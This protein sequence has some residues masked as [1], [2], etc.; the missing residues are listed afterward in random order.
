[1]RHFRT[2]EASLRLPGIAAHWEHYLLCI[3]LH[4]ILPLLPLGIEWWYTGSVSERSLTLGAALYSICIGASSR[5]AIFFVLTFVAGLVFA[6]AFGMA[7][8]SG[9]GL[10][11]IRWAALYCVSGV[12]LL[13]AL[14]RFIRHV[15]D[16][17]PFLEFVA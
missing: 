16:R 6:I 1:M 8:A 2:R 17:T 7:A 3:L 12:F 11:G 9:P 5:R 10:P 13:H 14:E 15:V 4:L